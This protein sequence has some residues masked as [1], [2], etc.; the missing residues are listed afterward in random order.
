MRLIFIFLLSCCFSCKGNQSK[1]NNISV[2][3]NEEE[4]LSKQE[5]TG[6]V[7]KTTYFTEGRRYEEIRQA[8]P[9]NPPEVIDIIGNRTNPS[10]KIRLSQLFDKIEYVVIKQTPDTLRGKPIVCSNHIYM[11]DPI[12]GI[13]QFDRQGNF[14][15]YICNSFFPYTDEGNGMLTVNRK[16]YEISYGATDIYWNESQL[17][18]KYEDRPNKKV[19]IME[20]DD[21]F[22]NIETSGFEY[23]NDND[24]L[25]LGTVICEL[26][27]TIRNVKYLGGSILVSAQ[28]AK[29]IQET[30][31]FTVMSVKGDTI[32]SFQDFDP[33]KDYHRGTMR[34]PDSGDFYL[35]NG[36][37]NI[38][39][40]YNDTVYTFLPPNRL[41][42]KYILDFGDM[43]IKSSNEGIDIGIRLENKLLC[44]KLLES[45]KHLF[46]TYTKDY[47]CPATA[48]SG[49]LKYSRLIYDKERRRM[50]TMYIDKAPDY[51]DA[52]WP[53]A[54]PA[55]VENDL[56]GMPFLWPVDITPD[57]KPYVNIPAKE[58]PKP[59]NRPEF[60]KNINE[61]DQVILIYN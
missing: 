1:S 23:D 4:M 22:Q 24:K 45:D 3:E 60:L 7:N 47:P 43:G 26:S 37:Y 34:N 16:Q 41:S 53:N 21:T 30:K 49:S 25:R 57:G 50:I 55:E 58:L 32:C 46:I 8:D 15:Q 52:G 56:D 31:F 5:G 33:I 20:I 10:V 35:L 12:R 51:K 19:F 38:R 61:N 39:Q 36:V 6:E 42:P 44:P 27:D 13:A 29:R 14:I 59:E 2:T 40:S 18:Y 11:M 9:N 17:Y 28:N 54:L 48:K